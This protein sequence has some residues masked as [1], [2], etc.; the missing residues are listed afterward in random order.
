M[1]ANAMRRAITRISFEII[2]IKNIDYE[3]LT[4]LTTYIVPL[5]CFELSEPRY[6]IVLAIILFVIGIIYIKTDLFYAN[7]TL[8]ILQFRIYKVS[9]KFR[10]N[11]FRNDI[12]LITID[13]LIEKDYV[14]YIKIDKHIYYAY[15]SVR[16]GKK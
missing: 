7:P 9:G 3:H 11:E 16:N 14:E 12:V 1:D 2:E 15:K 10:N 6:V 8:A 13:K 4:F 5:V